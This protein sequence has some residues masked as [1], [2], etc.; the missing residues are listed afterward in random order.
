MVS[1]IP[2]FGDPCKQFRNNYLTIV[3]ATREPKQDTLPLFFESDVERATY[4]SA[5][6]LSYTSAALYGRVMPCAL[7]DY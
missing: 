2:F 3:L 5:A 6:L 4:C 1:K 7:S